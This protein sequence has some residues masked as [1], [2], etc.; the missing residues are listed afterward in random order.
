V[1]IWCFF[2]FISIAGPMKIVAALVLASAAA[3]NR[4]DPD[5][6]SWR[7]EIAGPAER[8]TVTIFTIHFKYRRSVRLDVFWLVFYS[9]RFCMQRHRGSEKCSGAFPVS[10]RTLAGLFCITCLSCNDD[11]KVN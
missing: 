2:P 7:L 6:R 9:V 1:Y 5:W 4:A 8:N 11:R 10:L 3:C